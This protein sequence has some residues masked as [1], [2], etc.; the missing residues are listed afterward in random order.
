MMLDWAPTTPNLGAPGTW[1]APHLTQRLRRLPRALHAKKA[2]DGV[3][4]R[5][6]IDFPALGS[7]FQSALPRPRSGYSQKEVRV[8]LDA[9]SH[10]GTVI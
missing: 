2:S 8:V 7:G 10:V 1:D 9:Q 5:E 3:S 6:A 4:Q